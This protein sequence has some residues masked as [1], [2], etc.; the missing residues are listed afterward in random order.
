MVSKELKQ[1][2]FDILLERVAKMALDVVKHPGHRNNHEA[3]RQFSLEMSSSEW[4][5][6]H[7]KWKSL[8]KRMGINRMVVRHF[9]SRGNAGVLKMRMDNNERNIPGFYSIL[10]PISISYRGRSAHIL[11]IPRDLG[12]KILVLGGLPTTET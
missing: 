4:A 7:S 3:I 12:E 2:L 6:F 10:D 1:K 5:R 9:G 11:D 8:L